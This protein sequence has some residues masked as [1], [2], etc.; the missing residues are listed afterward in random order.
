[1]QFVILG[2][3]L[4]GPLPLYDLRKHIAAGVSL[5]YAASFGSI[6]RALEGLERKG[7]VISRTDESSARRRKPFE[8]TDSGRDAWREWMLTPLGGSD[9]EAQ[10][11]A[12]VFFLGELAQDERQ[13]CTAGIRAH[14]NTTLDVLV[15]SAEE[16][17]AT[18][19][20]AAHTERHAYRRATLDYGIRSSRLALTWLDGVEG[21]TWSS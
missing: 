16:I 4:A 21:A 14:V 3:L 18:D 6:Q 15:R 13:E 11:L 17:D 5:F 8:I 10:M 20:P 9:G 1:M 2:I 19:V 12:K 7:W